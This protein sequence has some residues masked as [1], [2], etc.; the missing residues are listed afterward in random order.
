MMMRY[1]NDALVSYLESGHV[2]VNTVSYCYSSGRP[3]VGT[4]GILL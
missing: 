2:T 3:Y 1:D 4:R